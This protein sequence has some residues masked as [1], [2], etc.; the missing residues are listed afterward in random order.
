MAYE[1]RLCV[2]KQVKR[3]F[4]ADGKMLSGAVHAERMGDDL[5]LTVRMLDIAP[6]REG[7][8][9]VAVWVAG[10]VFCHDLTPKNAFHIGGVPTLKDGFSA[11]ICFIKGEVE[12]VAYGACGSAPVDYA[13]LLKAFG[14][15]E[16]SEKGKRRNMTETPEP[17]PLP[18]PLREENAYNDEAIANAD[19]YQEQN[20][21]YA[22]ADAQT[23]NHP[24]AGKAENGADA[25]KDEEV[26]HPFRLARGTA[27]YN[28]IREKL[29]RVFEKYPRDVRLKSIFPQSD[30][31]R[32][33]GMLVGIVYEEG[34]PRFLCVAVE[35]TGEPPKE[36]LEECVFVPRSHYTRDEGFY[37]VFQDAD[38][39][40]TV[41][42]YRA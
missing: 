42:T 35:S 22:H 29:D 11:L 17:A 38:T 2:L 19:Y 3:G 27:Y 8:Y 1:K 7:R 34:R 40:E 14:E 33:E 32:A 37:V 16:K 26:I 10:R 28:Q 20:Q 12:P 13:P 36:I 25:A 9:A 18:E 6:V 4:S 23:A 24:Q 41:K 39:G 5:T 15:R 31:V 30:W 21:P